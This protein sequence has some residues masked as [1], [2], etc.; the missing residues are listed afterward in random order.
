M[1]VTPVVSDPQYAGVI[2]PDRP[3]YDGSSTVR[4]FL[5]KYQAWGRAYKW[6]A[7]S[8]SRFLEKCVTAQYR[9][10]VSRWV[11]PDED[12]DDDSEGTPAAWK[13]V[14]K[15]FIETIGVDETAEEF[16]ET[17]EQKLNSST[18]CMGKDDTVLEWTAEFRGLVKSINKLRRETRKGEPQ[19]PSNYLSRRL[20]RTQTGQM[21]S[22]LDPDVRV[23]LAFESPKVARQPASREGANQG[24][25]GQAEEKIEG[26]RAESVAE[27]GNQA[28]DLLDKAAEIQGSTEYK[29][30]RTKYEKWQAEVKQPLSDKELSR[31][32]LKKINAKFFE[33]MNLK[34]DKTTGW[35]IIG[36]AMLKM[37]RLREKA[38]MMEAKTRTDK[39]VTFPDRADT[40]VHQALGRLQDSVGNLESTVSKLHMKVAGTRGDGD[41][42]R[43]RGHEDISG[44]GRQKCFSFEEKG[45]CS[46]GSRCRFVHESPNGREKR[47]KTS[48]TKYERVGGPICFGWQSRGTCRYGDGCRFRHSQDDTRSSTKCRH[49]TD[50]GS[51]SYGDA[52]RFV[53][54]RP[55][56]NG[57][58][59]GRTSRNSKQEQKLQN[60][61]DEKGHQIHPDRRKHM[62]QA[63]EVEE[64][65]IVG[66][67]KS[68]LERIRS[69]FPNMNFR[70]NE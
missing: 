47:Q 49:W 55:I 6:N 65:L 44:R 15:S 62:K 60:R 24:E 38:E 3:I 5:Y 14:K 66:L 30:V 4:E 51:C 58:N 70:Q 7:E 31:L 29:Q 17:Q 26:A 21:I 63:A 32:F 12:S 48:P 35:E 34:Y 68:D 19:T 2:H 57:R 37:E 10:Y 8:R 33:R 28:Q 43:K 52:C 56:D 53:H 27:E 9:D 22:N 54:E 40:V 20:G 13:A 16:L 45:A 18:F 61:D 23:S 64:E 50:R 36:D 25:A 59:P 11:Y 46:Y 39:K 69:Q 42:S 1:S 41:T 67:T